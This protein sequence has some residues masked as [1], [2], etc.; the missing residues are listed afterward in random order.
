MKKYTILK[1]LKEN[2]L[3]A[4]VRGKEAE[5][6]FEISKA[7]YEGGIKNIEVTFTTPQAD[8]V[9]RDLYNKYKNTD[10]VVGAGTVMD[11]VTARIAIISGAKFIVSP[12]LVPEIAKTCNTYGIPY[13]P[14]CATVTE[15][16][17]AMKLGVDVAKV[18]PGGILGASFIKNVHG[19]IPHAEMM[20]SG[21]VSIENMNE[22]ME[23][24]AWA[25]G[26]GSALTKGLENNY[27]VVTE[28]TKKFVEKY[29]ELL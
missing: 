16:S 6:A 1:Q 24:G 15:I 29:N 25:V 22:W 2:F 14:G 26:V 28:N 5:D 12:N 4:V 21:G 3:F 13:L 7:V 17:E 18:F 23:N 19:P 9:I 27:E 20:P 10:M 8:E 11:E